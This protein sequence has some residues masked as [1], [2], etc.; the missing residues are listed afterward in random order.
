MV[1]GDNAAVV[2]DP[3]KKPGEGKKITKQGKGG[4]AKG[5]E[6]T[7]KS[8]LGRNGTLRKRLKSIVME[9]KHWKA[10]KAVDQ[11]VEDHKIEVLTVKL[12]DMNL[13]VMPSNIRDMIADYENRGNGKNGADSIQREAKSVHSFKSRPTV[14]KTSSAPVML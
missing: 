13:P 5:T 1:V 2:G 6:S 3:G 11:K 4:D 9:E 7:L 10:L 12:R 8:K 14:L